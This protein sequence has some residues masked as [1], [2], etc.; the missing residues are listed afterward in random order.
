MASAVCTVGGDTKLERDVAVKFLKDPLESVHRQLFERE[1]KAIAAL[2]KH[3]AIVQIYGWGEV[4]NRVYFALEYVTGSAQRLLDKNPNG[5]EPC[6]ALEIITEAAD[7]LHYAHEQGILHRDVKPENILIDEDT[8]NVKVADFGLAS[9]FETKDTSILGGAIC[10][11]PSYMSPEQASGKPLSPAADVFSL[12]VTLYKLICGKRPFEGDS[13]SEIL[14]N[15]RKGN[16]LPLREQRPDLDEALLALVDKTMAHDAYKRYRSAADLAS[17][18]RAILAASPGGAVAPPASKLA[19]T[20]PAARAAPLT[21]LRSSR[22]ARTLLAAAIAAVMGF[23]AWRYVGTGNLPGRATQTKPQ[24]VV[25]ADELLDRGDW[26]AAEQAY[27]KVLARQV[28]DDRALYGLGYALLLQDKQDEAGAQFQA[29][30][31]PATRAEGLAAAAYYGND[32]NARQELESAASMGSAF[33]DVLLG[34]LDLAEERYES[35]VSRLERI[36]KQQLRFNWQYERC[37]QAAGQAYYHRQDFTNALTSFQQV[38]S[39]ASPMVAGMANT[40]IA[41]VNR[42]IQ[43]ETSESNRKRIQELRSRMDT[44]TYKPLSEEELWTSRPLRFVILPPESSKCHYGIESGLA[45][46]LPDLLGDALQACGPLTWVDREDLEALLAEQ[47]LSVHLS[48]E[49]GQLALGRLLGARLIVKSTFRT[50]MGEEFLATKL[51]DAETSARMSPEDVVLSRQRD[52]RE[53]VRE[54]AQAIEAVL[55]KEYPLRGRLVAGPDGPVIN[56]GDSV[57]VTKGRRFVVS[58][59]PIPEK[60]WPVSLSR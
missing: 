13:A 51:V 47:E 50:L 46:C 5:I 29:S 18:A 6:R 30:A 60:R 11:S 16:Y 17:D 34:S 40:Y 7:G 25:Y 53:A 57:G 37:L 10:G 49:S 19:G 24:G 9:F 58:D 48:S 41:R 28:G 59:A 1:A 45:D 39:S 23:A 35:V 12:G 55:A 4:G 27:R 54:T 21:R 52:P 33:A 20:S 42:E 2:G 15:I 56:I 38:S 36:E 31:D 43:R 8:G 3:R 14:D 44:M 26:H 32:K 22:L